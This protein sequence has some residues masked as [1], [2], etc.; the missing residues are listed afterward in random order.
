MPMADLYCSCAS[1]LRHK[2]QRDFGAR[3]LVHIFDYAIKVQSI[4]LSVSIRLFTEDF[5][6]VYR[7]LILPSEI[8]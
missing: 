2:E 1:I 6:L 4:Y 3:L 5:F 8:Y 7:F